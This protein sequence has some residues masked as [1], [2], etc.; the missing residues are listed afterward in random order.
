MKIIACNEKDHGEEIMGILNHTIMN[1]TALFDYH[2][3][4]PESM[5]SWFEVKRKHRFPVLGAVD[6]T[7][8]LAGFVSYGTFRQWPA[9]KYTVEHSIY[10]HPDYR[11]R[12]IGDALLKS[13]IRRAEQQDYHVLI[14]GIESTN[15]ASIRLHEKNGF[16]CCGIIEQAGF[17]FG[18]W[19]DLSFYQL[20][21]PSP[22]KPVDGVLENSDN[23]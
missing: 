7:G 12:T 13:I 1:S 18:R 20:I 2:P 16:S 17:K 23:K 10:I 9:Y 8:S 15:R 4:T 22:V 11:R 3:R 21:L 19:L 5:N 14:G 6:T